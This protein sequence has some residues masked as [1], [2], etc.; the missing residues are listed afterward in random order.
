MMILE[1]SCIAAVRSFCSEHALLDGVDSLL[2]SLSAGKDSMALLA[3]F[4]VIASERG[5]ALTAFHLNHHTRGADSDADERFVAQTC[6]RAGIECIVA[7]H[8]FS[9]CG[10][11]YEDAAR[12]VRYAHISRILTERGIARAATA[13]S[14]DDQAETVLMRALAGT[15]LAGLAGIPLRRD[16]VIRPLLGCSAESIRSFLGDAGIAWREDASNADSRYLR[17][18]TRHELLPRARE[19]FPDADHALV[20]LAEHAAATERYLA[21]RILSGIQRHGTPEGIVYRMEA[22]ALDDPFERDF[23]LHTI[24]RNDMRTFL[25]QAVLDEMV[26]NMASRNASVLLYCK[27]DQ[28]LY[29]IRTAA[30]VELH[31]REKTAREILPEIVLSDIR[32]TRSLES[33][34]AGVVRVTASVVDAAADEDGVLYL[35]VSE[36][37]CV[38]IG[39]RKKGETIDSGETSVRIK[40][41]LIDRRIPRHLR[42]L[43]PVIRVNGRA[44]ALFLP[45]HDRWHPR[46]LLKGETAGKKILAIRCRGKIW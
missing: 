24:V 21:R 7:H 16:A 10:A 42:E 35:G 45:D 19:R 31:V 36:R 41:L 43:L 6:D 12:R 18:W 26:R 27:G 20:R 22:A 29:R 14:A 11:S 9:S 46:G 15:G 44:V 39:P 13:H 2:L 38:A 30:G 28:G 40:H 33:E 32:A 8:D 23:L 1:H 37:D 25:S 4:R 34:P 5:I 17:N 3:I